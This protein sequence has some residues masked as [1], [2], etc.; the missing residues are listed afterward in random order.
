[1]PR[2]ETIADGRHFTGRTAVPDGRTAHFLINTGRSGVGPVIAVATSSSATSGVITPMLPV[3]GPGFQRSECSAMLRNGMER[4][5]SRF[6]RMPMS[7]NVMSRL[8]LL[9]TL[10]REASTPRAVLE[11]RPATGAPLGLMNVNINLSSMRRISQRDDVVA[12]SA[13]SSQTAIQNKARIC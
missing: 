7:L 4:F 3:G 10:S 11:K 6:I 5:S 9:A 2:L 12:H 1:M 13:I 8:C